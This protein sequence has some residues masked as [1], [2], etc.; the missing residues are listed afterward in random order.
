MTEKT[1]CNWCGQ[2]ELYTKYHDKEWG[3]PTYDDNVLF[4]FLVLETFQAGLSWI[5]ILRKRESFREAF[6]GFDYNIIANYSDYKL[7]SLQENKGIIRNKLKIKAA[8]NN[9]SIFIEIQKKHGSFSNYIWA[10]VDN[11]P[12]IN[13]WKTTSEI[14]AKTEL[15]DAITKDM[16]K[17]GF[18]FVGSVSVYAF[19]QSIGLV[20]DHIVDCFRY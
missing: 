14:P 13:N 12:I 16:K 1:R 10:F 19:M 4:E 7:E 11:K 8:R 6:D 3:T 15:S 5:T 17:Q 9:A 18:K 20:N 2:D